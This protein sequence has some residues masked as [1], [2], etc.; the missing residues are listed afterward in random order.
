[1]AD[2]VGLLGSVLQLVGTIKNA[3]DYVHTFRDAEKQRKL[4]LMEIESLEP[5]LRELDDRI[6]RSQA[7]E[8]TG[9]IRKLEEPLIRFRGMMER[10]AEKLQ[11]DDNFDLVDRLTW[12]LWKKEDV[13]EELNIVE[14][15]KSSLTVGLELDIW[16]VS[17]DAAREYERTITTIEDVAQEQRIDHNYIFKSVREIAHNQEQ[18]FTA[19]ERDAIIEWYSP[20]NFFV[21]QAD[22][23]R[24]HQPGTGQW[25]LRI[26]AFRDWKNG[27]GKVLWCRGMPG[28]GKTV[29]VSIVVEHLRAEQKHLDEIGVAAIYLNHKETDAHTPSA[30][31][32][33]LW[34]QLVVGNAHS[35]ASLGKL[36]REHRERGTKPSLENDY[37]ILCST[38]A[39]YSKAFILV[40][41][42]D[43]YP[44]RERGVLLSYLSRLGSNVNLMLT[45]REHIRLHHIIDAEVLQIRA[46]EE[47]IRCYLGAEILK[48]SRLS[49]HIQNCPDLREQIETK[50][51]SQSRGMFLKVKLHID[52]LTGKHTVKAVQDTLKNLAYDLDS[53][54]DQVIERINRQS[55]DDRNLAMRMLSWISHAKR[56]LRPSELRAALAVEPETIELDPNNLVDVD[57]VLSVCAGLL[58][59][60]TRDNRLRLVYFTA[61]DYLER[62]R[63]TLFPHASA[64][65]TMTCFQY[66]SYDIFRQK[67]DQPLSLF[68]RHSLLDYAVEYALLHA[69]GEPESEI[70]ASIISFL[71][72]ETGWWA[73]WNWKHRYRDGP[74]SWSP[75]LIAALFGLQ[76]VCRHILGTDG[77]GNALQL[78]AIDGHIDVVRFLIRNG[79]DVHGKE[80]KFDSALH[81]AAAHGC[82]NIISL[83]LDRGV[84]IECRGSYGTP[85]QVAAYFG[86]KE[87]IELLIAR[88]ANVNA[89]GGYLGSS[90]YAAAT[91]SAADI[92]CQLV[93][94]GADTGLGLKRSD[95][96]EDGKILMAAMA[97]VL[98]AE[99]SQGIH[100]EPQT[101]LR[102]EAISPDLLHE[103]L[104]N[105]G[106]DGVRYTIAT[107]D[108]F[109]Q[110]AIQFLDGVELAPRQANTLPSPSH[111]DGFLKCTI[112]HDTRK[113]QNPLPPL[114]TLPTNQAMVDSAGRQLGKC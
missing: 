11:H 56:L 98:I 86:Q 30:L 57:T 71:G 73:L 62:K 31:L 70:M 48:S 103:F 46:T 77:A 6:R 94:A 78:A 7:G 66:L 14:R 55:E 81:A 49:K 16:S 47:D 68:H 99:K 52:S 100:G 35:I 34:R 40:D 74:V 53:T 50:I 42:L 1:M 63:T 36:Y 12:L 9:G 20:L 110:G 19:A 80:G 112:N 109:S 75:L 29:L 24:L 113:E 59:V 26:E 60:D 8:S 83:F 3:R 87:S 41:A 21:R 65:I 37:A 64:Q 15:F 25:F 23:F 69:R 79:V 89:P 108:P 91:R 92:F 88:G 43:E 2:I 106:R 82:G 96:L 18:H 111:L 51:V 58:L 33:S 28:A 45:S 32:T 67:T 97:S 5:L 72:A 93:A 38:I 17:L 95:I 22:V 107:S 85:L 102:N 76:K 61:Q 44:E 104:P 90:L 101:D 13:E 4:L 10:L 27:N 54:Y 84:D 114:P 39:Q 105:G